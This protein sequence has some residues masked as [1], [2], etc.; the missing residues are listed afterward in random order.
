M[1]IEEDVRFRDELLKRIG[2]DVNILLYDFQTEGNNMFIS[3]FVEKDQMYDFTYISS[4]D[5]RKTVDHFYQAFLGHMKQMD[6]NYKQ[7]MKWENDNDLR[8]RRTTG[9][10]LICLRRHVERHILSGKA[11]ES[12]AGLPCRPYSNG[13]EPSVLRFSARG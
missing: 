4:Y 5:Y 6:D 1:M 13:A 10:V 8:W 11:Q 12:L 2:G 9:Q 7:G 3:L